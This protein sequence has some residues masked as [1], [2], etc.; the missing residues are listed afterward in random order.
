MAASLIHY[1]R[2]NHFNDWQKSSAKIV[3][4]KKYKNT[5]SSKAGYSIAIEIA[6]VENSINFQKNS[7]NIDF[8]PLSSDERWDFFEKSHVDKII[9]IW[10]NSNNQ[11]IE[12]VEPEAPNFWIVFLILIPTLGLFLS[13]IGANLFLKDSSSKRKK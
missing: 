6:K 3:Q 11:A 5:G 2:L 1:Y 9:P 7:I 8:Y 13:L 12:F 4:I 10:I